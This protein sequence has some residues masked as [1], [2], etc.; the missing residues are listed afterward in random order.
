VPLDRVIISSP[1]SKGM[2]VSEIGTHYV[3]EGLKFGDG[4]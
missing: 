3:L 4:G 1:L 2:I